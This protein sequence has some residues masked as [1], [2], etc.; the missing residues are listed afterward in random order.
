MNKLWVLAPKMSAN[1]SIKQGWSVLR[2]LKKA[3]VS[4]LISSLNRRKTN[5]PKKEIILIR[6]LVTKLRDLHRK[7]N[8]RYMIEVASC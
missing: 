5:P 8:V 1:R 2:L 4:G 7:K 6:Q 3:V